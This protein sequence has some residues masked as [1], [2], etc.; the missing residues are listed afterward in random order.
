MSASHISPSLRSLLAGLLV[1]GASG[2]AA[3][4]QPATAT[5]A[6]DEVVN[7]VKSVGSD[8]S[9][10]TIFRTGDK[11]E[12]NNYISE[13]VELRNAVALELIPHVLRAV[14]LEKGAARALTFTDPDTQKV[15]HFIQVVTTAEQMPSV[16]ET[17][18]RFDLTGIV[19]SEGDTKYHYRLNNRKASE[20]ATIL[21]NTVLSGDGKVFWDNATNTVYFSDL[22]S[23]TPR[24]IE[25]L[26]FY[27]APPPQIE[28]EV[29][30]V[31]VDDNDRGRLGLD[32]DAWKMSAGGQFEWTANDFESPDAFSRM[33]ALVT[34]DA[35]ALTS[36]LNYTVMTGTAKATTRTVLTATNNSPAVYSSL[37]R[38]PY[39]GHTMVFA[40]PVEL[41]EDV[42]GVTARGVKD[43]NNPNGKRPVV[44]VPPSRAYMGRVSEW[45]NRPGGAALDPSL[46]Q[47]TEKTE[48]MYLVID[49]TIGRSLVTAD[50]R[51]VVNSLA[52]ETET[53]EPIISEKLINT[54]VTL[55]DGETFTLGG[56]AKE[57]EVRTRKG[58]PGLKEIPILRYLF[59]VDSTRKRVSK[60]Y[61]M[62]TP[63]FNNQVTFNASYMNG[64]KYD[65]EVPLSENAGKRTPTPATGVPDF[66]ELVQRD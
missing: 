34:V 21:A 29:T 62:V 50:V 10:F 7:I 9:D 48:G 32:W 59:S 58:I 64:V 43:D 23:K 2:A 37:R 55:K 3:Q 17:I 18:R 45:P 47:A 8:T 41:T 4:S 16:L 13:V 61:V 39:Y 15:R 25:A 12:M 6:Q 26:K 63:K 49:P 28:F 54:R 51:V 60:T 11:A 65:A 1:L 31:E 14:R 35:A 5:N 46:Q 22:V 56:L 57:T 40:T 24:N 42:P 53:G 30:V 36:F 33:D 52:G 20:V 27:D 66:G 44:I 19:A 38:L